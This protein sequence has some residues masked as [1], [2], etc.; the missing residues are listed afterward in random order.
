MGTNIG[1]VAS[2]VAVQ[3]PSSTTLSAAEPRQ[4]D[5]RVEEGPST[6]GE[7]E[8]YVQSICALISDREVVEIMSGIERDRA[9]G[10]LLTAFLVGA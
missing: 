3:R 1:Q 10:R 2:S 6:S 8:A 7:I 5:V 4:S 9:C